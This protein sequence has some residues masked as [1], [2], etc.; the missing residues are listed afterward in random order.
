VFRAFKKFEQK[1]EEQLEFLVLLLVMVLLRLPN[2]FEPY[3][4]GDEAIYLTVGNAIKNGARLYTDIIDHK[5]PII[6]YLAMVPSQFYF[7]LLNL[8]WMMVTTGFFFL[9]AKKLFKHASAAFAASL[10]FVLLTTLPWLEG[11]IPNGELFVLGFVTVGLWLMSQTKLWQ[12]FFE[13]KTEPMTKVSGRDMALLVGSGIFFGLGVLTKVPALLDFGAALLIG[14]FV[15]AGLIMAHKGAWRQHLKAL[16]QL[17]GQ[18]SLLALGLLIPIALSVAYFVMRGSGQDYL[19]YGLLYNLR[20]SGS[21]QLSFQNPL[22]QFIFTLPGKTL[23]LGGVIALLSFSKKY[24]PRFKFAAGWLALTLFAAL[25]SNRPYPHYLIQ[26][27]PPFALLLTEL[28]LSLKHLA[29][30]KTIAITAAALLMAP[31]LIGWTLNVRPYSA[32][33]YYGKFIKLATGQM[34]T[35]QYD[36]SFNPFI[37]DNYA[38]ADVINGLNGHRIFIW[39][40]NPMLYALTQTKPTSR[41]TVSFHI[42]DFNDYQRTFDQIKAE[43]PKIIVVM[44][45]E[46]I[47]FPKLEQYLN[48]L[49]YG[50]NQY[51]HLTV[52]LLREEAK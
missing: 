7:R 52:Y 24:T 1:C 6:Y 21:W 12:N 17:V 34:T 33:E 10:V 25:L 15:A 45:D 8:G 11:N 26:A 20:Y 48:S 35:E 18:S 40:T 29:T 51:E 46:T 49:Y 50:N 4:Y 13:A 38:V 14:W 16:G 47:P 39:G 23:V 41:F 19:D 5:T 22:L 36:Y 3:W 31:L 37:K 2:F 42:R 30:R 9:L 28:W 32:S 44:N 43:K 27:V